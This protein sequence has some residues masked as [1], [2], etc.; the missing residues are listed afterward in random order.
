MQ[1]MYEM[2]DRQGLLSISDGL[3][4]IPETVT[5]SRRTGLQK[6]QS[7]HVAKVL[8][9]EKQDYREYATDFQ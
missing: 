4:D 5:M 8:Y 6:K 7:N 1:I 2:Q 9:Q 3:K